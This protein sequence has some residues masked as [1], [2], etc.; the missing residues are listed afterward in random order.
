MNKILNIPNRS[1]KRS[2]NL[3]LTSNISKQS[4]SSINLVSKFLKT[5]NIIPNS[6]EDVKG[7]IVRDIHY[8][9]TLPQ[10]FPNMK[11][12]LWNLS[13]QK[14]I[15]KTN[16]TIKD[17]I[18]CNEN[19]SS[20]LYK[21]IENLLK[22]KSYNYNFFSQFYCFI[23]GKTS[24]KT[25]QGLFGDGRVTTL[26]EFR[27]L[28]SSF[29]FYDVQLKG[30]GP[31]PYCQGYDGKGSLRGGIRE[32]LGSEISHNLGILTAR[33]LQVYFNN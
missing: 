31:T 28:S 24:N 18:I 16:E 13:T 22:N 27:S 33:C 9:F 7:R 8:S 5:D 25:W 30:A 23:Y 32:F 21:E 3:I 2:S 15:E 11:S 26:G 4:I 19:Q 20:I 6:P 14:L 12:I 1:L 10:Q 29:P 17:K